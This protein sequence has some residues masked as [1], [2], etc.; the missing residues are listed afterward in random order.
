MKEVSEALGPD[1]FGKYIDYISMEILR[2]MAIPPLLF[3]DLKPKKRITRTQKLLLI[4][5]DK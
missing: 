3:G 2:A 5:G 1:D 4:M